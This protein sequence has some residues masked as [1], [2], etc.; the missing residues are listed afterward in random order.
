MKTPLKSLPSVLAIGAGEIGR[1]IEFL[2]AKRGIHVELWDRDPARMTCQHTLEQMLPKSDYVFLCVP[3]WALRPVIADLRAKGL[4]KRATV[5]ALSKGMEVKTGQDVAELLAETLPPTQKFALLAGPMLAEEIVQD[6]EAAAVAASDSKAARD[7]L[8]DLFSGTGLRIEVSAD[9]RG[10]S[11]ASVLKNVYATSLGIADGLGW[12]GNRKGWLTARAAT[13]MRDVLTA[14]K[15]DPHT[16]YTA[17]GLGDLIATGFSRY[18]R[19]HQ[20][21]DDLVHTGVIT[22]KS[23]GVVAL[24]SVIKRLGLRA[25]RYPLLMAIEAVVLKRKPAHI[26]FERYYHES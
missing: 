22:V 6:L 1:A 23:E 17:A 20:V 8:K 3:S 2:L 7:G 14:L 5:V 19:N 15:A 26:I 9:I 24:P 16:V 21:G 4:N 12:G 18:S 13:E 25:K 11:I 10:V